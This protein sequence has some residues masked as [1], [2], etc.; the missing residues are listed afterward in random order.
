MKALVLAGGMGTRLRP[1]THA[2]PKQLV[3]IANKPVLFH[4]L[5]SIRR[6][7]ITEVGVIVGD[8]HKE[9]EDAAGDGTAFGLRITYI[10]QEAPFGLAHCVVLGREFLADDDFVMYLGDNV[11]GD[12]IHEMADAF[13]RDRPA[14]QV[15]VTAVDSPQEYGIAETGPDGRVV[16]LQ[17]KPRR[18]RSN[19]AVTGAY[20][21]SPL[22]HEAVLDIEPSW[23]GEWEIT[24][25]IQLLVERDQDVRAVAFSGWWKDTGRIEDILDCNRRLLDVAQ[26][27]VRGTV[28]A[29]STLLGPVVV[30]PGARIVRSHLRGPLIVGADS[31]VQDSYVGPHTS[32][33]AGCALTDAGVSHSILLDGASVSDVNGIHG[34]VI[35][36]SA[37][38]G[39]SPEGAGRHRLVVG[40]DTE[41][42]VIA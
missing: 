36:R 25:A 7:G 13:R 10:H 33:G 8:W 29:A 14:A 34:S 4:G 20:F 6:A 41:L 18:P 39:V 3:P 30:E 28:D 9:I 42:E 31:V 19:L 2:M 21:F 1:L 15:A 17:E 23:R 16:R 27:S 5:E 40:D 35:G 11:F 38:V 12:G 32:L 24:D 22:I 37:R 26:T